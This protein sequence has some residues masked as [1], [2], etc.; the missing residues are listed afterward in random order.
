MKATES[1]EDTERK[2]SERILK[3]HLIFRLRLIEAVQQFEIRRKIKAN[4]VLNPKTSEIFSAKSNCETASIVYIPQEQFKNESHREHRG[5]RGK[6][7][8]CSRCTRWQKNYLEGGD[9]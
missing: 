1:T 8:R 5:H 3:N 2:Y 7:T 6:I 9:R 4:S